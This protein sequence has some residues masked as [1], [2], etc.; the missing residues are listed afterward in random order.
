MRTVVSTK[1]LLATILVAI[2]M[3]VACNCTDEKLKEKT[4]KLTKEFNTLMPG[5]LF[6]ESSWNK[7]EDGFTL[8]L[9]KKTAEG[10]EYKL[11]IDDQD[12]ISKDTSYL[13][14]LDNSNYIVSILLL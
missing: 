11:T 5:D 10:I 2:V 14:T 12:P 8:M 4:N 3:F 1:L 6:L 7:P 13:I 9:N